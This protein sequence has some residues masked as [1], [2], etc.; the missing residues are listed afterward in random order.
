M[1]RD[2]EFLEASLYV[3]ESEIH[4]AGLFTSIGIR[5]GQKI[6]IV[7]GE[8]IS[9][10]ECERR[11]DEGN[12]YIFWNEETYIDTAMTDKIK[13]INHSCKYN[14]DIID[15]DEESLILTAARNIQPGEELTIDYGY[16]EIYELCRCKICSQYLEELEI[17]QAV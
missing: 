2:T 9:G 15:R 3:T 13:F 12:V 17:K 14:C 7:K 11:E 4:G 10:E 16:E 1:S 6:M 5:K 8:M